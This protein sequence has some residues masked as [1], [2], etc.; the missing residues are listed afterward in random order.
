[1]NKLA[2]ILVPLV[3]LSLPAA[4]DEPPL[5]DPLLDHLAGTWVL[6]G[7][8]AGQATTHDVAAEWVL[9][10][11]YVRL[12]EV[13]RERDAGGKPAYEAIVFVGRE[14]RGDGYACLWLDST[15]GGGLSCSAVGHAPPA[16]EEL[17]FRFKAPDGSRFRTTFAY[18]PGTDTWRWRMDA[19]DHGKLQPFARVSL[20]RVR[21]LDAPKG[22]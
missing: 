1:L 2:G 15:G 11:Q 21:A 22:D 13:S 10:H 20:V 4:A 18:E 16:P 5:Q 12:H 19:E 6:Q 9:G 14:P 8:I 7:T 17:A 3:L